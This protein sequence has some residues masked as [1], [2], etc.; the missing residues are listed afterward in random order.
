M[1]MLTIIR[2]RILLTR[3]KFIKNVGF[4]IPYHWQSSF[5]WK[6]TLANGIIP[7]YDIWDA[8]VTLA[9]PKINASTKLGGTN[10]FNNRYRQYEDGPTVGAFYYLA[11]TL[12]GLLSK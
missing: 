12:E 4:N 11:I 3:L 9:L 10:I 8:Q 5:E 2:T 6:A 1:S 7:A